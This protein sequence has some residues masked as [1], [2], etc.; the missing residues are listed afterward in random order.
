MID[1]DVFKDYEISQQICSLFGKGNNKCISVIVNIWN[2]EQY[3]IV[4]ENKI[5]IF[6][7]FELQ[8]ALDTYNGL[9]D[10]GN[11]DGT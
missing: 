7:T 2:K 1:I 4:L 9:T 8:K 5:E 10:K 6:R 11:D 3:F